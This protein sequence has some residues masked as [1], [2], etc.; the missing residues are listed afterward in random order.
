MGI[1]LGLGLGI[2][3]AVGGAAGGAFSPLDLGADLQL[4][5][6]GQDT[7]TLF[8]DSTETTPSANGAN[9]GRWK[10]KSGNGRHADKTNVGVN[11][12]V[13]DDAGIGTHCAVDFDT[14]VT[15]PGLAAPWAGTN[16]GATDITGGT[17]F[18]V[19]C[20]YTS[21][22]TTA[23]VL[24]NDAG[25]F[26]NYWT[27]WT[28]PTVGTFAVGHHMYVTMSSGAADCGFATAL[29]PVAIVR[30]IIDTTLPAGCAGIEVGG[31]AGAMTAG[32]DP[33]LS[34]VSTQTRAIYVGSDQA[35]LYP[36]KG[37]IGE[38]IYVSRLLTPSEATGMQAYLSGRW[39]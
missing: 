35:G 4:W 14:G 9:V 1:S 24:T 25:A 13:R 23:Y 16:P 15:V 7:A 3:R 31:V 17:R 11:Y 5:L 10:D 29:G 27:I 32:Y 38:V 36:N 33:A 30:G 8:T 6:D 18:E 12:P 37:A 26:A 19:W 21:S 28:N 2:S 20:V 39:S 34:G 22:S